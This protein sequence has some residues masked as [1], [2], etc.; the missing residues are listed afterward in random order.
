[1][2]FIEDEWEGIKKRFPDKASQWIEI[3]MSKMK[4]FSFR[5]FEYKHSEW[6]NSFKKG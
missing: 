6:L 5:N 1:M 4:L 3:Y 2:P